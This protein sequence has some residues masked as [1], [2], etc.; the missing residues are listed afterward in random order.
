MCVEL[1]AGA[2]EVFFGTVMPHLGERQ[3]RVLTGA[4]SEALGRGGQSFVAQTS[5]IST[6]TMA[7][8]AREVR[9]GVELVPVETMDQVLREALA[10]GR[11]RATAQ[12]REG[13]APGVR[14]LGTRPS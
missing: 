11:G 8:A 10:P 1:T 7:R 9:A 12:A 6:S 4:M 5:G 14:E 3:R 2:A 13:T